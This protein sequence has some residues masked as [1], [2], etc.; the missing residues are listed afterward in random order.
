VVHGL[1]ARTA[2][3]RTD[4]LI[5]RVFPERNNVIFALAA[6]VS[7]DGLPHDG[8]HTDAASR[9]LVAQVA[10]DLLGEAQVGDDV[11][12]HGDITISRYR[13]C[14]KWR[15]DPPY[16]FNPEVQL[17]T[18]LIGVAAVSASSAL[19]RNR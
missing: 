7:L 1:V 19:T 2:A 6:E 5:E 4:V 11:A 18:T 12:S 14:G 10:V 17:S 8:R 3:D 15:P 16:F 9:G 13:R